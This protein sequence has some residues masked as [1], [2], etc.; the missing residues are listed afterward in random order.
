MVGNKLQ[1]LA[2]PILRTD[3]KPVSPLGGPSGHT[4][5]MGSS[6]F[7]DL[8]WALPYTGSQPAEVAQ[9]RT[10]GATHLCVRPLACWPGSDRLR[11]SSGKHCL[12]CRK[13]QCT[14]RGNL[15]TVAFFPLC[16]RPVFQARWLR[17]ANVNDRRGRKPPPPPWIHRG[18]RAEVQNSF[19]ASDT[20]WDVMDTW[21]LMRTLR[22]KLP[23]L[24][25]W[26]VA[27]WSTRS[28][29]VTVLPLTDCK[30]LDG[31]LSFILKS[32]SVSFCLSFLPFPSF[33]PPCFSFFFL[34]QISIYQ[35]WNVS[36]VFIAQTVGMISP[37][38]LC[39]HNP[40]H[41]S[42]LWRIL[43]FWEILVHSSGLISL[44]QGGKSSIFVY[45]LM[46]QS[47]LRWE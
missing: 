24:C 5:G 34:L 12:D 36:V 43:I 16:F 39:T 22:V 40:P 41:P 7:V 45:K 29:S 44:R 42:I 46:T 14:G 1:N 11:S 23:G 47:L 31:L 2:A 35:K 15:G 20:V 30:L 27:S 21:V 8:G 26:A 6:R 13:N 9:A 33:L 28:S 10:T 18:H 19:G 25:Q 3:G 32:P 37:P 17:A 38:L 4:T